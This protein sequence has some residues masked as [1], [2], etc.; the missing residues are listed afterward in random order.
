NERTGETT[1]IV[2]YDYERFPKDSVVYYERVLHQKDFFDVYGESLLTADSLVT[3]DSSG[4]K[5]LLFPDYIYVMCTN[6]KE[7]LKYLQSIME[8]DRKPFYQRSS[9]ILSAPVAIEVNGNYYSPQD[10][11]SIGYWGWSEK[12]A[13]T[14][15]FDYEPIR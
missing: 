3:M 5:F 11:F 2:D 10:F 15:P 7:E 8:S 12:I 4:A 1:I 13:N 14:L 9:A 6:T